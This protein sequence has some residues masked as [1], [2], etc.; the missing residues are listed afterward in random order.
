LPANTSQTCKQRPMPSEFPPSGLP[1]VSKPRGAEIPR[2]SIRR[3]RL[4]VKPVPVP[5]LGGDPVPHIQRRLAEGGVTCDVTVTQPGRSLVELVRAAL[6][7][8]PQPDLFIAAGGDGTH[9]PVGATLVGTG[10]PLGLIPLGTFN[11][12]ARSL[13]IPRDVDAALEII[14][15]AHPHLV[16]AGKVNDQIFFEVAGAG[17]DAT[18]FPL[19]EDLKRGKFNA[20]VSSALDIVGYKTHPT[21]LRLDGVRTISVN[22][23]TVV[24]A[25]G[26]YY[27][28][29]FAVAPGSRL[30]DGMF[31]VTV[32]DSFGKTELLTYFAAVAEGVAMPD[33]RV[34]SYRASQ[35][36]VVDPVDLPAHA[37]GEPLG[38]LRTPFEIIP[39]A[40]AVL[41]SPVEENAESRQTTTWSVADAIGAEGDDGVKRPNARRP[42]APRR[43]RT[44]RWN[45]ATPP[46]APGDETE[47]G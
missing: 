45:A 22:T 35:V 13:G 3:V 25:N 31:N 6:D 38:P 41:V 39:Q 32:F 12:L 10:V 29:S 1:T 17:W 8:S 7:A 5:E 30:D 40:L 37:D 27:G 24:V 14:L 47:N 33:P 4:I 26:P 15:A 21:T 9:G 36:E 46:G 23:P 44:M 43:H 28:S 42:G 19:G 18:L 16:D 11:N 2:G 20:L 34:V